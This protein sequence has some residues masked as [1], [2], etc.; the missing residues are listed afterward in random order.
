MVPG[1]LRETLAA[2]WLFAL[3]LAALVLPTFYRLA[4]W[5]WSG[6]AGG[7]GPIVLAT[8][9]WLIWRERAVL[10][11]GVAQRF[12]PVGLALFAALAVYMAGRITSVL[13]LECGALYV[14]LLT[15]AY[16]R[17]GPAVC[18]H[19]WFPCI[20]FLFLITPPEN[21]LVV[22]TQPLKLA[23]SD[24]A[25]STLSALGLPVGSTG[26]NIQ[27]DNYQLLVATACSGVNSLIGISALS[28]FYV[29]VRHGSAPRYALLLTAL[30]LPIAMVA[31][32]LRIVLLILITLQFGEAA[33]QGVTHDAAGI[34][35]FMLSMVLLIGL[36]A[37]LHPLVSRWGFR[38]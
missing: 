9:I 27:V 32:F 33:G 17:Y 36:D 22:G 34:F 14:I 6:D 5:S 23:I 24:L 11:R 26:V 13:A 37:V 29:Y 19:F 35:V 3:G 12:L 10:S 21:W 2:N 30:I 20:Y 28:L 8:G 15:L 18:R 31:N 38:R 16:L 25:V 1:G 4:N 7:H